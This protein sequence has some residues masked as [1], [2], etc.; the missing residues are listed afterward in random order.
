MLIGEVDDDIDHH[1]HESNPEDDRL[2]RQEVTVGDGLHDH[3]AKARPGE[4]DFHDSRAPKKRA[5]SKAEERD[6]R[7]EC[8]RK[9]FLP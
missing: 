3:V 6:Q 8:I 2:H 7:Q 1:V 9:D 5:E 4:N